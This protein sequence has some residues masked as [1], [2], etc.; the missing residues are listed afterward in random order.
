MDAYFVEFL[1]GLQK[2]QMQER[3]GF[4]LNDTFYQ[5]QQFLPMSGLPRVSWCSHHGLILI[6]P[7]SDSEVFP[8]RLF[9][10]IRN[11]VRLW[12]WSESCFPAIYGFSVCLRIRMLVAQSCPDSF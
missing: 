1:W 10:V 7:P 11:S 2:T 12:V 4:L 6:F 9:E 8:A 3:I 5:E